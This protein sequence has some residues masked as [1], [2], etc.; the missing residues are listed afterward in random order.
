[1]PP[2]S[3]LI[4]WARD[5]ISWDD[6][7]SFLN[8]NFTAALAGALAGALVA[9]R[10][11]DRAKQ[12]DALLLEIRSTNAAITGC[13]VICNAG[14]AL[15]RQH[16]RELCKTYS[17]Q[18][19]A[20]E[21]YLRRRATGHEPTD[22]SFE[23]KADFRALQMP[24]TPIDVL[25]KQVFEQISAV[26]RPLALVATLFGSVAALSEVIHTRNTLIERF[27]KLGPEGAKQLPAF[28]FGLQYAPGHVSTEFPD[29]I[30][31]LQRTND[32]VIFFSELL[33]KDLMVHGSN[34]LIQFK[35][36]AK[37]KTLR[38]SAFDFAEPRSLGLMPV[39]ADYPDWVHGFP[40]AN[41]NSRLLADTRVLRR[42]LSC[43][44]RKR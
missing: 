15:K 21:E 37:A 25:R 13:F 7:K 22:I 20:H 24:V 39:D 9:R 31:A 11:G 36:I 32:D 33:G 10:I 42:F 3:D 41:R 29:T 44:T 40:T 26:G 6:L 1:M 2:V 34:V 16:T 12:R 38:I 35:K 23:I 17:D 8:S 27:R 18:K 28:Y 14:L 19:A 30:E 5:L 4:V 43:F